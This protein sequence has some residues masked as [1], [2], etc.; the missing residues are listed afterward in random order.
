[1]SVTVLDTNVVIAA[2][3]SRGLCES[4]FELCLETHDL[5]VS[6]FLLSE[7][8]EKLIKRLRLPED[9]VSEVLELYSRC[10]RSIVPVEVSISECRDPEDLLVLGTCRAS[11]ADYLVTGDKDLLVLGTFE[12]TSIVSPRAFYDLQS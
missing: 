10:S 7:L 1:M 2:F 4:L 6:D 8:E 5:V 9:R 12:S 11:K 3:A